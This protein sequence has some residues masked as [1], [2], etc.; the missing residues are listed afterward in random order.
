[1]IQHL[2]KDGDGALSFEEFRAGRAVSQLSEDAQEDRFEALDKNADL[3][4]T[5][6]ELPR[7]RPAADA[8]PQ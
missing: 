4:L 7:P 5:P 1:M 3:K 2:D 8:D 6:D